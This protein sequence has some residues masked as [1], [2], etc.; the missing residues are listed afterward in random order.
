MEYLGGKTDASL[1]LIADVT[2]NSLCALMRKKKPS[3]GWG[4]KGH[5]G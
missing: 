3:P 5:G 2:K 1:R 4:E